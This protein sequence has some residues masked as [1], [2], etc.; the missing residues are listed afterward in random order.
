MSYHRLEYQNLHKIACVGANPSL[1]SST[2]KYFMYSHLRLLGPSTE[3]KKP[4]KR[5]TLS[6]ELV[7]IQFLYT[8]YNA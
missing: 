8:I 6:E 1:S 7:F 2:V 4:W 3:K 5:I